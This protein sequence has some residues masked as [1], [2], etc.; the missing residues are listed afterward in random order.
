MKEVEVVWASWCPVCPQAKKF[1][2]ELHKKHEFEYRETEISTPRGRELLKKHRIHAV[3]T[4]LINGEVAFV[5]M[6]DP[7][8]AE[9]AIKIEK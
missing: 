3:P 8:K 5:G 7:K 1:W 9:K 6:P 2:Q 4:T